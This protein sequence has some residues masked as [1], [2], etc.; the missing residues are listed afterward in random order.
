MSRFGNV[1]GRWTVPGVLLGCYILC[2]FGFVVVPYLYVSAGAYRCAQTPDTEKETCRSELIQ[3]MFGFWGTRGGMQAVAALHSDPSFGSTGCFRYAGTVGQLSYRRMKESGETLDSWNFPPET[4]WCSTGFFHEFVAG[5]A[6]DHPHPAS[7]VAACTTLTTRLTGRTGN[8]AVTCYLGAGHGLERAAAHP[9]APEATAPDFTA[10]ALS[11][12]EELGVTAALIEDCKRGV[13]ETY[14]NFA[15]AHSYGLNFDFQTPLAL[16]DG[17]AGENASACYWAASQ[18]LGKT[19]GSNPVHLSAETA[20]IG[21]AA[22]REQVFEGGVAM[23]MNDIPS[24]PWET[25][26]AACRTLSTPLVH[27]CAE[28]IVHGLFVNG[29]PGTEYEP[30][31]LFCASSDVEEAGLTE[32]CYESVTKWAYALYPASRANGVCEAFPE[33]ER[34]ICLSRPGV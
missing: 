9:Y 8:F 17:V 21:N 5:F 15:I 29:A 33:A 24:R 16:C 20:R 34:R 11:S 31:L 13:M 18:L 22:I 2:V 14:S 27:L 3:S 23:M 30:A 12:C 25:V 7:V 32:P 28:G 6:E 1:T 19:V 10:Q 26:F 4:I